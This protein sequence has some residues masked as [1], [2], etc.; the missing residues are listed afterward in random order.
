L[1]DGNIAF[2]FFDHVARADS[3]P[4]RNISESLS[5]RFDH[6]V[7]GEDLEGGHVLSGWEINGGVDSANIGTHPAWRKA[8]DLTL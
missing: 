3:K 6:H 5:R 7:I 2:R 1:N 8:H 4:N